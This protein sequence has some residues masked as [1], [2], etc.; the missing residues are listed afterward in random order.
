MF[1][2]ALR[3]FPPPRN[4]SLGHSRT[5]KAGIRQIRSG[6]VPQTE[7]SA[8]RAIR[9]RASREPK[10][11]RSAPSFLEPRAAPQWQARLEWRARWRLGRRHP[12]LLAAAA[13]LVF[14]L[15]LVVW[16]RLSVEGHALLDALDAQPIPV[17]V[18]AFLL[19]WNLTRRASLRARR[20]FARSW[21]AA[22]PLAPDE[23]ERTIRRRVGARVAPVL[24]ALLGLP[25]VA[26]AA[27]GH[28]SMRTLA[29]LGLGGAVGL[30]AGWITGART[31]HPSDAP[32]PRLARTR[33]VTSNATGFAALARW[34]FARWLADANPR[35]QAQLV[36]GVLL[37]LPMG[38]PPAIALLLVLFTASLVAAWGLLQALLATIPDATS[39]MR[40]TPVSTA[41]FTRALCT[42]ACLAL[43]AAIVV[44]TSCLVWLNGSTA[45]VIAFVACALAWC[46]T[47]ILNALAWRHR[48]ARARLERIA[49]GLLLLVLLGGAP[50]L[51]PVALVPIWLRDA[52]HLRHA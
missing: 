46:I 32:L 12:W 10:M 47:A 27:T 45:M 18:A 14:L 49:S 19:L 28:P 4:D 13:M 34:P 44:A 30:V 20:D 35:L 36:A 22:T 25:L 26:M 7:L 51:L 38:I 9:V 39:W 1:H 8:F 2:D 15:A 3:A 11:L 40:A 21:F 17:A 52:L 33:G 42:R 48:P 29:A 50:W 6:S 23:I 31:P 41:L 24:V 16:Q 37:M 5:G 43:A